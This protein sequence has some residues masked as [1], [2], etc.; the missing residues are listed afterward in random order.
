MTRR[1]EKVLEE[2]IK[3]YGVDVQTTVAI[4]EMSELVKELCKVKRTG[5]YKDGGH[6][7]EEIADV[8]IMLRQLEMIFGNS[9][10]IDQYMQQKITRL[11]MRI[12][13]KKLAAKEED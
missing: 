13:G 10:K 11:Q 8:Y 7:A 12:L 5:V 4:E 9:E 2:A 1:N 6:I 3:L